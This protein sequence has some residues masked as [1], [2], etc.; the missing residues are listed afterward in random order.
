M[1]KHD[2]LDKNY[3]FDLFH[4]L[5]ICNRMS[6]LVSRARKNR[7]YEPYPRRIQTHEL[8][9]HYCACQ[10]N[11]N[12]TNFDVV[13]RISFFPVNFMSKY[14]IFDKNSDF[15]FFFSFKFNRPLEEQISY[16]SLQKP[17]ISTLS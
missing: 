11:E 4:L 8:T 9:G 16:S 6:T 14:D 2:I 7:M 12:S 5:L 13:E 17:D 3:D 15:S 10:R 1:S